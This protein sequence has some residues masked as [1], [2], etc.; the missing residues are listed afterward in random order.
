MITLSDSPNGDTSNSAPPI[1]STPPITTET[2]IAP[3]KIPATENIPLPAVTPSFKAAPV[4]LATAAA[5]AF[6]P[7][8]PNK[9][10]ANA[11]PDTP[12]PRFSSTP[13]N[14]STARATFLRAASPEIPKRLPISAKSRS[15]TYRQI[16]SSRSFSVNFPSAASISSIITFPFEFP[17][18]PI[19]TYSSSR[20]LRRTSPRTRFAAK[21]HDC[22]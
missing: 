4:T 3:A 14:F 17:D 8:N 11:L 2:P 5:E 6:G 1:I 13:R 12:T 19:S 9:A 18:S 7:L 22:R 21:R 15:S 16:T 10:T 20:L